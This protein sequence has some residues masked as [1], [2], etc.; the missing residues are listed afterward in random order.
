MNK[1]L[2]LCR[3]NVA[4]IV[5]GPSPHPVL[6]ACIERSALLVI[7]LMSPSLANHVA[8]EAINSTSKWGRRE[9]GDGEPL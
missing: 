5:S 7:H 3:D 2:Q 1:T 4:L 6:Q 8:L 9:D